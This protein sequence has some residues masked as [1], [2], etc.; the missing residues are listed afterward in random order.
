M[1]HNLS[2]YWSNKMHEW[3]LK[4]NGKQYSSKDFEDAVKAAA[5]KKLNGNWKS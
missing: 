1:T 3:S 4:E 5:N 2:R